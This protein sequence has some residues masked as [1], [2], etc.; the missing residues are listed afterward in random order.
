MGVQTSPNLFSYILIRNSF[1]PINLD[2][3]FNYQKHG[4]A[5]EFLAA[6]SSSRSDVVTQSICSSV[7]VSLFFF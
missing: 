3:E 7:C 6:M 4:F 1:S 2:T 5:Q